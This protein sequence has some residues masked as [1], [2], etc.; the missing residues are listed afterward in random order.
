VNGA[1]SPVQ[2]PADREAE[3]FADE[4]LLV[5]LSTAAA[6]GGADAEAGEPISRVD[7]LLQSL[8]G[9]RVT[10]SYETILV[11]PRRGNSFPVAVYSYWEDKSF[12]G[13]PDDAYYGRACRIYIVA[14]RTVTSEAVDCP[15]SVP[16]IPTGETLTSESWPLG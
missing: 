16:E 15:A 2:R 8:T 5:Q 1:P 10:G 3:G 14:D 13:C 4:C 12:S 7:A 11:G 6:G 9:Q